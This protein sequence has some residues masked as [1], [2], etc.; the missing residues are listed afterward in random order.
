[1]TSCLRILPSGIGKVTGFRIFIGHDQDVH[2]GPCEN[3]NRP[4]DV[5]AYFAIVFP[6]ASI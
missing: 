5:S 1:M 3:S 2:K 4:C 6:H